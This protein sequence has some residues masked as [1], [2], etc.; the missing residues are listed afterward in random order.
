MLHKYKRLLKSIKKGG[1]NMGQIADI[2]VDS[3]GELRA[4]KMPL[5]TADTVRGM[6][7]VGALD[8]HAECR[9]EENGLRDKQLKEALEKA[10][11]CM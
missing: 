4:G 10:K 11:A 1:M 5:K 6:G 2:M 9:Q 3:I 7:Y 8:R